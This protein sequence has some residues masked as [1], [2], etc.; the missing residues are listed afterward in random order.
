MQSTVPCQNH[1]EMNGS[2]GTL[3]DMGSN[4]LDLYGLGQKADRYESAHDCQLKN[5]GALRIASH[6]LLDL[7]HW[8]NASAGTDT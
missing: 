7:F 8:L 5:R 1:T 4:V 2:R 3:A 6:E